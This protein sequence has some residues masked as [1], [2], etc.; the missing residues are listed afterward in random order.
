MNSAVW[1]RFCSLRGPVLTLPQ[2]GRLPELPMIVKSKLL[3]Q[4]QL[5]IHLGWEGGGGGL[6]ILKINYQ[7][8]IIASI[9]N[10]PQLW[11]IVFVSY[12]IA[13]QQAFELIQL[14]N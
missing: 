4:C 12:L 3:A 7:N 5:C 13:E 2:R 1:E 6:L 10:M 9:S 11:Q 14:D 8:L